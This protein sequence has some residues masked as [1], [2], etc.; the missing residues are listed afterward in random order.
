MELTIERIE[1]VAPDQAS[2]TAASK[3]LKRAKWPMLQISDDGTVM[4]GQCQGSGSTPYSMS[5][6]MHDL[7]AKCSCPSRKFPCKHSIALM[8]WFADNSSEFE[9]GST[10]EWV[11]DWLSRRRGSNTTEKDPAA[12]EKPKLNANAAK[13]ESKE[14][15]L[16][17][18]AIKAK[19]Q[20][21]AKRKASNKLAREKSI[22]QGLDEFDLWL[23]DE[24]QQGLAG[25]DTRTS[26]QTPTIIKRLVDAKAPGM[27]LKIENAIAKFYGAEFGERNKGLLE[28]LGMLHLL[29]Q[30][31]RRQKHLPKP[32][33]ADV[34]QAIGWT[35][36][37]TELLEDDSAVSRTG[38]WIVSG[39]RE[40]F[41]P[42]KLIRKETWLTP[43][44]DDTK[45]SAV[46]VDF[47]HASSG[48]QGSSAYVPSQKISGTL[49]FFPSSIPMRALVSDSA[50]STEDTDFQFLSTTST[51]VNSAVSSFYN[52][53]AVQPWMNEM[54]T[55]L[56]G[57]TLNKC[58][59]EQLWVVSTQSGEAMR[60]KHD[61]I[62]AASVL[63]GVQDLTLFGL[64]DGQQLEPISAN[65]SLGP[66]WGHSDG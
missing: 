16:D 18:E 28:D 7:G 54:P 43:G 11:S 49:K 13:R 22:A 33:Q 31:Y 39:I 38:N 10:P 64:F 14:K 35:I 5:V 3:L 51:T 40:V 9:V 50:I 65:T 58:T 26:Q 34:R 55:A 56:H 53:R 36:D 29:A 4:W 42:D 41:Q 19:A 62:D 12:L 30:A 46:L 27:A 23:N 6:A 17:A 45:D 48:A 2:L 66:W 15:P 25:F 57:V 61:S 47:I 24:I 63:L 60:I 20:R 1:A 44:D 32:L 21:S 37:R 59:N 52:Q 8:W